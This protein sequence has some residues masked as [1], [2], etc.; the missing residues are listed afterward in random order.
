MLAGL[1]LVF[2]LF[3]CWAFISSTGHRFKVENGES[4]HFVWDITEPLGVVC[5]NPAWIQL[6]L[7]HSWLLWSHY[8]ALEWC[9]LL[10]SHMSEGICVCVCVCIGD[11]AEMVSVGCEHAFPVGAW[12][13]VVEFF[14]SQDMNWNPLWMCVWMDVCVCAQEYLKLS[15]VYKMYGNGCVPAQT[16]SPNSLCLPLAVTSDTPRE[17]RLLHSL[18][19]PRH[20]LFP[21]L[22]ASCFPFQCHLFLV[23]D[24]S[25]MMLSE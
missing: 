14:K 8:L 7:G 4:L 3:V 13:F 12:R 1:C 11:V 5:P 24:F 6:C 22:S 23:C 25:F 10:L 21:C 19:H 17:V 2:V 15:D 9:A 16:A 18:F 20:N